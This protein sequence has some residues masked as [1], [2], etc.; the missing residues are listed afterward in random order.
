MIEV[1]NEKNGR[2]CQGDIL[3]DI[4]HIEY[5]TQIDEGVIDVWKIVYPLVIVLTQDCDL[6]QDFKF[7][8]SEDRKPDK[9]DKYLLSVLVAPMYNYSHVIA[10]EHLSELGYT[11][12]PISAGKTPGTNLRN[13]ETPRYH[14]LEF[15]EGEPLPKSV[16]DFKHYFS[17]NIEYLKQVK[18]TAF[19][20]RVAELY[21]EDI[22][23]RF[24]SFLSRIGLPAPGDI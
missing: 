3:R 17:V 24:A 20:R 14:Y 10:G 12:N 8:W 22:S 18:E 4:E 23:M 6:Q 13:N 19:V 2:V 11:M 9:H 21:R 5:V 7:R 1:R 16:I 15:A